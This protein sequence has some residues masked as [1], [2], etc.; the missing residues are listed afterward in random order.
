MSVKSV[1]QIGAGVLLIGA[2]IGSRWIPGLNVVTA[3]VA[4]TSVANGMVL[5]ATGFDG[6][7]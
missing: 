7:K 6:G 3:Q 2:D 4:I 5:V 1:T